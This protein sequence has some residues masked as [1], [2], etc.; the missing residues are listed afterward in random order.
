MGHG[1]FRLARQPG[2][3]RRRRFFFLIFVFAVVVVSVVVVLLYC[4][5]NEHTQARLQHTQHNKEHTG[6][7]ERAPPSCC[8]FIALTRAPQSA[9]GALTEL[10]QSAISASPRQI[11]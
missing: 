3:L 6:S 7:I 4:Y 9:V 2:L 11:F 1:Y 8:N 5:N 10:L